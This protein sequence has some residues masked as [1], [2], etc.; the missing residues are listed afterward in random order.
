MYNKLI[1]F[2]WYFEHGLYGD[3]LQKNSIS[4]PPGGLNSMPFLR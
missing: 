2:N 3:L 1:F 4:F